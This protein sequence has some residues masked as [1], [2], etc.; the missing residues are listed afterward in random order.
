MLRGLRASLEEAHGV[1]IRDEAVVAAVELSHRYISGRQL[2]DKAVDL[3]DTARRAREGR[4]RG[5]ARTSS[6]TLRGA[7][8]RARARAATRSQRDADRGARRRATRQETDA[9]I[10]R[11]ALERRRLSAGARSW[12]RRG[13]RQRARE[14]RRRSAR[15]T[16]RRGEGRRARRTL[17]SRRSR[18]CE[19]RAGGE[20]PPGARRRRRGRRR[21]AWSP[22]GP[23]SPSA[24]WRSDDAA[25]GARAS[26]RRSRARVRGQDHGARA[27]WPRRCA[28]RT[29]AS[30]TRSTPRRRVPLRRARA[31][32]AR[33]RP[34]SRSPTLLYGGERFM[35]HHQH[36]RVPGEAHRL[37]ARSARR[38]ATSATARAACSPRR[39]ASGPYSVVL[40]DE[41]E[42]ADPEV[43]NLF[44]QVFD[45]GMLTDGE[46][47]AVD[48][49]NTRRSS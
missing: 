1:T 48:F 27:R 30:A 12:T 33:P 6:W 29:R 2:P 32:S 26:R 18:R 19:P 45:K 8:G 37:A 13:V 21:R 5:P 4:A 14:A 46:G 35:T 44:Y 20:E 39:C 16:A 49:K 38:P 22:T 10:E 42:K 28:P 31:A 7:A 24:R 11:R 23:A 17:T 9:E 47:R 36:E 3:L 40:L 43:M 34:R 15:P 25:G 41:C